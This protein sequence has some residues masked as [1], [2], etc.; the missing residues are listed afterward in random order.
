MAEKAIKPEM[1]AIDVEAENWKEAVIKSGELLHQG[2]MVSKEYIDDMVKIVE[3]LGPYI[4]IIPELAIAHARPDSN[5][6]FKVG[7]S[8]VRLKNPINFGHEKND[9]V[10]VVLGFSAVDKESHLNILEE[11]ANLLKDE[12]RK[13]VL[14]EGSKEDIISVLD[15]LNPA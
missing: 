7:L 11:L 2:G 1:I 15:V 13:K 3:E 12:E 14:F 10:K 4:V 5:K 6:C 8:F 9:P